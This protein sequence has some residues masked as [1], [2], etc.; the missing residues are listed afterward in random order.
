MHKFLEDL[1]SGV[2]DQSKSFD[3]AT[4]GYNLTNYIYN[5][6]PNTQLWHYVNQDVGIF[7]DLDFDYHYIEDYGNGVPDWAY[8]VIE[9][10]LKMA[11]STLNSK[12]KA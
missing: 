2:L 1:Q 5:K 11:R 8:K 12:V 4:Y 10:M 3:G 9:D 7:C 6:Q